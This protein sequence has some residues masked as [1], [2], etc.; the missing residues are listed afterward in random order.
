MQ[1]DDIFIK[2]FETTS[3]L[4]DQRQLIPRM[5]MTHAHSQFRLATDLAFATCPHEAYSLL[6]GAIESAVFAEKLFRQPELVKVWM[7]RLESEAQEKDFDKQFRANRK[8]NLFT[9]KPELEKLHKFWVQWSELSSHSSM[10]DIARRTQME[11]A[12]GAE[13]FVIHYF[14]RDQRYVCMAALQILEAMA[15][16]EKLLYRMFEGRL[17]LHLTLAQERDAF[18]SAKESFRQGIIQKFG[19]QADGSIKTP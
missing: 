17:Q 6:R 9:G 19:I 4:S 15:L 12:E 11:T 13:N 10:G 16:I 18:A 2:E 7:S 5:L 14:E 3:P 8:K 1:L